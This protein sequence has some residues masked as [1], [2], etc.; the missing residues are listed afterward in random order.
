MNTPGIS[1]FQGADT[2]NVNSTLDR[3]EEEEALQDQKRRDEELGQ[4]L[5]GAF[6]DLDDHENTIDSTTNYQSELEQPPVLPNYPPH[7]HQKQLQDDAERANEIE[8]HRLN[9]LLESK[10]HQLQNVNQETNAAHKKIDDL[11]KQLSIMQAELD[12]A[13]R[14]KQ[15]THEL[16]VETKETCSN[17]DSDL[18]KLRSEKKQLKEDNTRLVGQLEITKT[19]LS[20]VQC[21]YNMVQA[22]KQQWEERSADLRVKHIED[23]HRA[24]CDLLQQ[25]LCQMKDQLD[26][27]QNELDQINSRYNALQSGHETMLLDKAAKINELSQALD[28]AQMRCN[29]LSARPDLQDENHRQRQCI[30]DL[31]ASI[32]SFE[33]TVASLHERLNKTTAELDVMDSLIQQHQADES[34]TGRLSQVGGSQLVGS[35][36][37]NPV[38]RVGH[39]K[40]ELYRAL[41]SLKNKR[42]EVRRL[43]KLLEERNQELRVLRNNENKSLVQLETLKDVKMRLE[44]KVKS[45]QQELEE[46][47]H[48]LQQ[49]SGLHSQLHAI[50]AERDALKEKLQQIEEQLRNVEKDLEQLK[51]Q[52][53][54][55]Q[56]NYDQL[57][58]DNRQLRT[59]ATADNLRLELERHKILLR[60]SQ[61]EVER[62]K[63]L[64][65]DIATDKEALDYEL[66]KLRESDTL[67]ELQDQLQ[68]LATVQRNLQLTEMKSEELK[69]LLEAEKLSHERDLQ[70]LRQMN[71]R[72]KRKGDNAVAKESSEN[73]SKCIESI[74]EITKSEIQLLKLQNVNSI[75]AKELKELEHELEQSKNL[76]A[77]MQEKIELSSKQD[78]LINDLKE[79][80]NQFEAYI[81]QQEE[82]KQQNKCTPSPTSNLESTPDPSPKEL[83]QNRIRLI[84]QRVRD[85]MAKLF[86]AELKKFTT[87]LQQSEERSQCLQREFQA[88]CGEL[89]QRQTEVNLLKQTILAERE[90]IDEVLAGKEE[91]Q[92]EMLQKCRQ[93]LQAKNQR[94]AELL[95]EVEEQHASID[96]ERQSMKAVMAQWEKQRK[97][98]DQ[99][100]QHWRQQLES[101]RTTHEEAMRSAQQRY[102]SAKRTAHNYKLY[103]EDKE[104]HMKREYE[105]IKHE[106]EL[107]LAKIEA[108]MNQHL[109]RRSRE[110]HRDKENVPSNS[111]NDPVGSS[112]RKTTGN[113]HS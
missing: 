38:D 20:E 91:K 83:T 16:L 104:A 95:R 1:L 87:R 26:R 15:N 21:K 52:H 90:N 11:Q 55:L 84:E 25:Q 45:M 63:K 93:E 5:A 111:S 19:L 37:L 113:S 23:T 34:P 39:I 98:V 35:T 59:R 71:E 101:L 31:K 103:A 85:E 79:K 65:S 12:R 69:K 107:S 10:D 99:V 3:Q 61:S 109:E 47:Q 41:A 50:E 46:Q 6:D 102:Q 51:Q 75:Q 4:M 54:S 81:R 82:H 106:Y 72:E 73:C 13:L 43:D 88:V 36:P 17:K 24:Q 78:E 8:M 28:D 42:E 96:S 89:Q 30:S 2:L 7:P 108:T 80:A 112:N 9:M 60:D 58:Q 68:N 27:K 76:Q 97:S 53:E 57:S 18:N 66:R 48:K 110:K 86:A 74:A 92:K 22:S 64:Y 100:E 49:D 62:L 56:R 33:Q 29:Q 32:A 94:I 77:E 70:A 14:E 67:K 105:R 44:N 40:Q